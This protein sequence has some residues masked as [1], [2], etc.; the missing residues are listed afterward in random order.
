MLPTIEK[1][2]F[3]TDPAIQRT[4]KDFKIYVEHTELNLGVQ[5]AVIKSI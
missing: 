3:T 5:P 4:I 1:P 2:T